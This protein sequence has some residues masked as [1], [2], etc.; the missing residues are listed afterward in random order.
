MLDD[1]VPNAR[2]PKHKITH[3]CT[4]LESIYVEMMLSAQKCR[5][6]ST[7]IEKVTEHVEEWEKGIVSSEIHQQA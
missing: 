3:K 7:N 6:T 4:R 1:R 5:Y 2:K